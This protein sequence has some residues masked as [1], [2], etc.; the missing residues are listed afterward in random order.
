MSINK[1]THSTDKN[2][3]P[4]LTFMKWKLMAKITL[5]QTL[6]FNPVKVENINQSASQKSSRMYKAPSYHKANI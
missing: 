2:S 4:K 6:W 1:Q 5:V 3:V